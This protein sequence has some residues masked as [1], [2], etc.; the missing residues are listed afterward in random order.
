MSYIFRPSVFTHACPKQVMVRMGIFSF[1]YH[2]NLFLRKRV[3]KTQIFDFLI[4]CSQMLVEFVVK[5]RLG[6]TNGLLC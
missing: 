6:K 1:S 4:I 2:N 5:V 3:P